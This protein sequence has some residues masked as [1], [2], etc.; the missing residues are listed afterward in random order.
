MGLPLLVVGVILAVIIIT[1]ANA[2]LPKGPLRGAAAILALAILFGFAAFSSIRYISEDE[3][4]VL[5]GYGSRFPK[6]RT[7][8]S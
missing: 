1:A 7:L 5:P 8:V 6:R 4:G 2:R 3:L